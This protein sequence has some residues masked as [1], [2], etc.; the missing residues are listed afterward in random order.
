MW[1]AYYQF[2]DKTPHKVLRTEG[3]GLFTDPAHLHCIITYICVYSNWGRC[4]PN[5][6]I[7]FFCCCWHWQ[8]TQDCST[9]HQWLCTLCTYKARPISEVDCLS[10]KTDLA[11]FAACWTPTY[12]AQCWQIQEPSWGLGTMPCHTL[13]LANSSISP[14]NTGGTDWIL[15]SLFNPVAVSLC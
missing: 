15:C 9:G 4:Q 12:Y 10:Q 3:K 6:P 8:A 7:Q 14:L 1:R 11:R 13:M 2:N 5:M